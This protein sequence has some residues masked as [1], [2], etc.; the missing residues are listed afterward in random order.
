[1]HPEDIKAAIRKA[2]SNQTNIARALKRSRST[3]AHVIEGRTKSK[4]VAKKIAEVTGLPLETLWPG[5]Y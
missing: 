5:K 4:R 2:G 3:V 1:M